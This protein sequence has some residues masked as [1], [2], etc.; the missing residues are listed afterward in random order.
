MPETGTG[1]DGGDRRSISVGERELSLP[2]DATDREAAAIAA[3]VGAHLAD[4]RRV[5]AAAAAA[6]AAEPTDPWRFASRVGARGRDRWLDVSRGEEWKA[7]A[8]SEY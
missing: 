8:R 1:T 4:R 3:A 2:A 5:A 6:D 7:A